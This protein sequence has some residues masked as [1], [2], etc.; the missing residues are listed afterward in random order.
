MDAYAPAQLADQHADQDGH[1]ETDGHAS[2]EGG[3]QDPDR[4]VLLDPLAGQHRQVAAGDAA[5][6]AAW[7]AAWYAAWDAALAC[8]VRDLLSDEYFQTLA[9]PWISVMGDPA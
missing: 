1:A 7:D 6:D 8:V 9:G 3:D 5:R 2:H 4:H